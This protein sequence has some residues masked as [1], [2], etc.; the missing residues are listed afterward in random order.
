MASEIPD[1]THFWQGHLDSFKSSDQT[2]AAYC[3]EHGLIIHRMAYWQKR[4]GKSVATKKS[5]FARAVPAVVAPPASHHA[6]RFVFGGGV[7]LEVDTGVDPIWLARL[8]G[9]VGGRQ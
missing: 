2:R 4:I 3:R 7:V 9:H 1:Q 5:G 8:V 6:A